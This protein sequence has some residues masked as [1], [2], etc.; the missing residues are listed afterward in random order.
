MK[1]WFNN[2]KKALSSIA[3]CGACLLLTLVAFF[4]TRESAS[5]QSVRVLFPVDQTAVSADYLNNRSA[6]AAVD[7]IAANC[8]ADNT[9][10]V[11]IISYSSPEGNV[12]YNQYLSEKRS[13]ALRDYLLARHPELWDR[14]TVTPYAEAWTD[15]RERVSANTSL[16][17]SVRARVIEIIDADMDSD[18]KEAELRKLPAFYQ[19]YR[20]FFKSLRYA[21]IRLV[22][23]VN[24]SAVASAS[25]AK[26]ARSAEQARFTAQSNIVAP[27]RFVA[28]FNQDATDL[29]SNFAQ[30]EAVLKALD[31]ALASGKATG[32]KAIRIV[33]GSSP[34]GPVA[35]NEVIS[36]RRGESVRAYVESKYPQF[37]NLVELESQGEAWGELR[38]VVKFSEHLTAA[39]KYDI[40]KVVDNDRLSAQGKEAALRNSGA[41]NRLLNYVLPLVRYAVIIPVF[42]SADTLAPATPAP[43]D[44]LVP[45]TPAEPDTVATPVK[46]IQK[47]T[48]SLFVTVDTVATAQPVAPQTDSISIS[49]T[50]DT[51]AQAQPAKEAEPVVPTVIVKKPLLA[52]T[53]NLLYESATVFTGFHTV[54][55][56]IGVEVPI[57]QHWSAYANYM[58]TAPWHA[59][60]SNADCVELLHAD[61]GARWYPGG[62][63]LNPFAPKEGRQLLDGWYAYA[64]VGAGYYDFERGGKGY[65][66]EEI[67]GT[68]GLGY[69]LYLGKSRTWSLDFALGGGPVFTQYR[70]YVGRSNNEHLVYQYS[71][72]LTYFG[73][74]DAKVTLR[75]LFH[76]NKK[77]NKTE[78][79]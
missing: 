55:L 61:L 45:A 51:V 9:Q 14:V 21:E 44:T 36:Q 37:S 26:P 76:Y 13:A 69:G 15:L 22:G 52:V 70:Y 54:P 1:T 19:I 48:T 40:L 7:S 31:E 62:S 50:V 77:V 43:A 38:E 73:V 29:D 39:Q 28:L 18:A 78:I 71:G 49:A 35:T 65:Q 33:S 17:E 59:W 12:A 11:E 57:G 16:S 4:F 42:E 8:L 27:T 25:S 2:T 6:L 68:L 58:A 32:L 64:A 67:L 5:A 30:N 56:N 10:F 75:Y 46:P 66:G 20:A 34:D 3:R 41:W 24:P 23:E 53:T 47:D 74:T 79:Q 72:K 63:F 60:N